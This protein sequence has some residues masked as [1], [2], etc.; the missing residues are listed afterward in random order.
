MLLAVLTASADAPAS[1][2]PLA[3]AEL[4]GLIAALRARGHVVVACDVAPRAD[5]PAGCPSE[6]RNDRPGT[7]PAD[8]LA[9]MTRA[10]EAGRGDV[11][12]RVG[13]GSPPDAVLCDGLV[14][15]V[16]AH[17]VGATTGAPVV[18]WTGAAELPADPTAR[19]MGLAVLQSCALVLASSQGIAT[20]LEDRRLARRIAVV[21]PPVDTSTFDDPGWREGKPSPEGARMVV[22]VV[23]EQA[24]DLADTL[25]AELPELLV[26]SVELPGG[27]LQGSPGQ[28]GAL[29]DAL[30]SADVAVT[31]LGAD[32]GRATLRAMACARPVVT[33]DRLPD[34]EIVLDGA[35]GVVLR[36]PDE[37]A[38]TVSALAQDPFRREALGQGALDRVLGAHAAQTVATRLEA[39]LIWVRR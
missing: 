9:L 18:L 34:A 10:A 12:S 4:D 25:R 30:R 32:G 19:R 38:A 1:T 36:H 33:F 39:Q 22:R 2:S 13:A 16:A 11:A 15:G 27:T 31:G 17:A 23:G 5:R 24:G 21:C 8:A 28:P 6:E 14:S 7:S 37:L 20:A 26:H 35:S 3:D 29:R